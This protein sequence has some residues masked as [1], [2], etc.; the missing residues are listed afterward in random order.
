MS[1]LRK[2]SGELVATG[3][4]VHDGA[5]NGAEPAAMYD[6]IRFEDEGGQEVYLER[7][8]VPAFLDSLID[9]GTKGKLYIVEVRVPTLFGSKPMHFIYAIDVNGKVRKA[10]E[11]T[12][13][14]LRSAKGGAIKLFGYGCV[15]LIAWGF[16]LLLWVQAFRLMRVNL[17]LA[18]MRVEPA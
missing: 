8:I 7:V 11:Q 14:C 12:Q 4:V 5:H 15:L 3:P 17:P 16:G 18:D 13:R 9:V 2:V 10:V 6:Y 1:I